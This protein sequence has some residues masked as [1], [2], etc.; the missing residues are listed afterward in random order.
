MQKFLSTQT[1]DKPT[2]FLYY[3]YFWNCDAHMIKMSQTKTQ[4]YIKFQIL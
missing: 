3:Q 2:I 1:S 4:S